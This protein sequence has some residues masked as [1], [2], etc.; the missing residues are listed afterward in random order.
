MISLLS[1]IVVVLVVVVVVV[2]VDGG[3]AV[4]CRLGRHGGSEGDFVFVPTH[5]R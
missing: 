4:V 3:D 5:A 2:D 1:T